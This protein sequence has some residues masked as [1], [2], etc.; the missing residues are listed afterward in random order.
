MPLPDISAQ[1]HAAIESGRGFVALLSS[2][3]YDEDEDVLTPSERDRASRFRRDA[4]RKNF[5]LGRAALR[6]LIG[7]DACEQMTVGV[8]GKLYLDVGPAFS[9]SHS[10]SWVAVAVGLF[11]PVGVDVE[12]IACFQP[13]LLNIVCSKAER[14]WILNQPSKAEPFC[15]CW[16]RKEALLK[17]AGLGLVGDLRKIPS[18]VGSSPLV[19]LP[20]EARLHDLSRYVDGPYI[21][22]AAFPPSIGEISVIVQSGWDCYRF[23]RTVLPEIG[24]QSQWLE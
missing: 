7:A 17:A 6:A 21:V 5:V 18:G 19:K 13:G 22:S 10:G 9:L 15:Q 20:V 11:D 12:A 3:F 8:A 2:E 14:A 1:C 24:S 23:D 4:D 16:T